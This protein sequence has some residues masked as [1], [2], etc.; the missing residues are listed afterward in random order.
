MELISK[1][2]F[3]GVVVLAG[4]LLFSPYEAFLEGFIAF[5]IV[6]AVVVGFLMYPRTEVFY[7]RTAVPLIDPD[8]KKFLEHDLLA[9]RVDL[10]RLW[11][12][13]LPTPLAVAS[14]MFFP[15]GGPLDV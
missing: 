10:V 4:L 14:R 3:L 11:L 7:V 6:A 12:V 8:R 5:V 2:L 9:V 1:A 15:A 13:V